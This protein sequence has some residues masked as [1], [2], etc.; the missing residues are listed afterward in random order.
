LDKL[1][2]RLLAGGGGG[3]LGWGIDCVSQAPD[4]NFNG[5]SAQPYISAYAPYSYRAV[6]PT[7][8]LLN[9]TDKPYSASTGRSY[10]DNELFP[11]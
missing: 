7:T 9:L 5:L 4:F 2:A 3:W 10:S 1:I 6:L 11:L 8:L